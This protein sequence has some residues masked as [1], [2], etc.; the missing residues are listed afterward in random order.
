MNDNIFDKY[1]GVPVVTTIVRDFY[2]RVLNRPN[3][4][5]YFES[6]SIED[7]IKHQVEFVALAMGKISSNYVGRSMKEAHQGIGVTAA[8]FDLVVE[9]LADTMSSAGVDQDDIEIII[10]N[11]KKYRGDIVEK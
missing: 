11:V 10:N 7:L 6:V 2:K 9:I 8:S 4:R 5:R 1:G 3:L